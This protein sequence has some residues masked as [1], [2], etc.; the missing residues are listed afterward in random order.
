[1]FHIHANRLFDNFTCPLFVLLISLLS[2]VS[3]TIFA[4]VKFSGDKLHN[5][6][7]YVIPIIFPFVGFYLSRFAQFSR[8]RLVSKMIDF[9]VVL[10]AMWRV[11]GDVPFVSGH[12]LFLTYALLTDETRFV[13]I[14]AAIVLIEVF[15][16]KIFVWNDWLTFLNGVVLGTIAGLISQRYKIEK[17]KM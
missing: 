15:I 16:L 5:Q 7:Y 14:T 17:Q 12:S 11:I 13:K 6:F 2:A 8:I 1:M 10:T 4:V 9:A 3:Y